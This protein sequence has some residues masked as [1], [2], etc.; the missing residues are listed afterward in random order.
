M[1]TGSPYQYITSLAA[2]RDIVAKII[3][4]GEP[5]A[6]DFE[7]TSLSPKE[8]RVRLVSLFNGHEA[9]VIDF[10]HLPGGFRCFASAFKG[11]IWIV[12]NA[13]FEGRWFLDAKVTYQDFEL[14]DVAYLRCAVVGGGKYKLKNLVEWDLEIEM[15]KEQQASDW[16]APELSQEQLDYSFLDADY[17]HRLWMYW[18]GRGTPEHMRAFHLLNG[19]WPAVIEMEDAGMAFD[20]E[21]HRPL[22]EQWARERDT[23]IATI[24][25]LVGEDEVANINSDTQWSDYFSQ[26]MPD[27]VLQGWPRTEKTGRLAMTSEVM[28]MLAGAFAGTPLEEFFEAMAKYKW[29]MKYLSSFGENLIA[30]SERAHDSRIHARFNVAAAKTC[31]FSSSGPNLQNVPRGYDVR[32][33][34]VAGPGLTLVSLDYSGIE[35]RVLA[36]LSGDKQLLEDVVFGDVHSEVASVIAGKK[37]DKKTPEGKEAR[38]KAKG[39]SFGIIYGSGAGGLSHTMKCPQGKAQE[40][41]DFWAD[42]YANAFDYRNKMMAHAQ[43]SGFLPM[44]DGGTIWVGRKCEMPKAANYPVQRA[45]L[46]VMASA[47]IKHKRELD[48]AR[49]NKQQRQ[50]LIIATIHDA[51]IDETHPDDA[52]GCLAML[53][54]DMTFGYLDLFPGAP[55]DR[56][57]EGGIGPSWGTLE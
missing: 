7:T 37:I 24:R 55:T 16:S 5:C 41:I 48:S 50:T 27:K 4:R 38:S 19:M 40:Y 51:V 30:A 39:V 42:R 31:R 47:L 12:F 21:A 33:S 17:T 34:F 54:R 2:A 26:R 22:I 43:D 14:W 15:S 53:E 8:G 29:V 18:M 32:K 57:V 52:Q 35:L 36:L 3:E 45:A 46:S 6:L 20:P 10:D 28:R 9:C 13:G 49:A 56:L 11:G 44:H 1:T 25:G 23:L